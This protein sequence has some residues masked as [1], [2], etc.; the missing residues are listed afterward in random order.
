MP[1]KIT[2]R[3]Y[4]SLPTNAKA[5]MSQA[6][7]MEWYNYWGGSV[8]VSFSGGKDS[9]VLAHLVHDLYPSVPL[10]F[11]NTG[12]EYPEVQLFA[13]K[14]SADFVHP[15]MQFSEV[16]SKYG[17][18]I[19]SKEISQI[20]HEARMGL[21]VRKNQLTG[22]RIDK[23][24]GEPS[25]F[26]CPKWKPLCLET[27]FLIS[28][29]CCAV[30]KKNPLI[31]YEKQTKRYPIIGTLTEESKLRQQAWLRHGCNTFEGNKKSSQPLSFW[32]EQDILSYIKDNSLEIS[33]I[34]G[35]IKGDGSCGLKCT[36]CERTGCMFCAFGAHLDKGKTRFQRLAETHPK[37]YEYCMKGGSMW[38][39]QNTMLPFCRQ[40][41]TGMTGTRKR[42][43]C[44]QKKGL[45]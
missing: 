36:G 44:H 11:C 31:A 29:K 10:V 43:G 28:H 40:K 7:I 38:T 22:K 17:Y 33:D 25:S 30:M 41:L 18:P 5:H 32:K 1:D 37:Q 27:D 34:Y 13:R 35:D 39:I 21:Q 20:I 3:Q 6:R 8:Y 15:K 2:L 23:K 9:T 42:F 24:T 26:N 19:I 12:L 4:Q 16:I 45:A 14:M